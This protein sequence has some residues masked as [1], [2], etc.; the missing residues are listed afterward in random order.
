MEMPKA[1]RS[2]YKLVLTNV[3]GPDE[4][5]PDLY[6]KMIEIIENLETDHRIIRGDFNCLLEPKDKKDTNSPRYKFLS[7]AG[8]GINLIAYL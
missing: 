2:S 4:D 1:L 6:I 3:Y 7:M 5:Q 8:G